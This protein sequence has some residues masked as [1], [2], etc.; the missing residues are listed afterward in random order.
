MSKSRFIVKCSYWL[1]TFTVIKA[2]YEYTDDLMNWL[3]QYMSG[4]VSGQLDQI[5]QGVM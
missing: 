3:F 5:L 2:A 4:L 1:A